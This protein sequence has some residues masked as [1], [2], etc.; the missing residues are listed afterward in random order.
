MIRITCDNC[1]QPLFGDTNVVRAMEY[2]RAFTRKNGKQY[3]DKCTKKTAPN[4]LPC[5]MCGRK[6]EIDWS[7]FGGQYVVSCTSDNGDHRL[8]VLDE[9]MNAAIKKWNAFAKRIASKEEKKES[10]E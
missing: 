8:S 9:D 5:P 7:V 4:A 1:G 3:C 10:D 2:L 6:P